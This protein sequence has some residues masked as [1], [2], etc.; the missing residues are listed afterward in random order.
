M[1]TGTEHERG[2]GARALAW[3]AL[4]DGELEKAAFL[5]EKAKRKN[6]ALTWPTI[7]L[8]RIALERG[9]AEHSIQLLEGVSTPGAHRVRARALV[10][11]ASLHP[12]TATLARA[13]DCFDDVLHADRLALLRAC[14]ENGLWAHLAALAMRAI[15]HAPNVPALWSYLLEACDSLREYEMFE[16]ATLETAKELSEPPEQLVGPF[17]QWS[18]SQSPE[19]LKRVH[20]ALPE[21]WRDL[22]V[23]PGLA[24][25]SILV[26]RTRRSPHRAALESWIDGDRRPAVAYLKQAEGREHIETRNLYELLEILPARDKWRRSLIE[27]D[28]GDVIISQIGGSGTTILAFCGFGQQLFT[29]LRAFDTFAASAGASVVYLRDASHLAFLRGVRSLGTDREKTLKALRQILVHLGTR[30]LVTFGCSGGGYPAVR[31]GIDIDADRIVVLSGAFGATSEARA[32]IADRR[33]EGFDQR[34]R[35]AVPENEIAFLDQLRESQPPEGLHSY[36]GEEHVQDR[37]NAMYLEGE[38]GVHLHAVPHWPHHNVF[39]PF[40]RS[41]GF[42]GMLSQ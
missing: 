28:G 17:R 6:V 15:R 12:S 1:H 32:A 5:A 3:A 29:T 27:D 24:A 31:Y 7:L 13:N 34:V 4:T 33:L 40:L 22:V 18:L 16:D 25:L 19:T 11:Q 23:R 2:R 21:S 36:F 14:R 35:R 10:A 37:A 30:R 38:P 20:R 39:L 26:E 8:A 42:S 9:E 41:D